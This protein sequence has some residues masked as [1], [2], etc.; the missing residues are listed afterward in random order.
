[1]DRRSQSIESR[2]FMILPFGN[3]WLAPD[4]N[5]RLTYGPLNFAAATYPSLPWAWRLPAP[6]LLVCSL[7]VAAAFLFNGGRAIVISCLVGIGQVGI[8]SSAQAPAVFSLLGWLS[9]CLTLQTV[10][11]L[12]RLVRKAVRSKLRCLLGLNKETPTMQQSRMLQGSLPSGFDSQL[13]PTFLPPFMVLTHSL[14]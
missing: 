10:C 5:N 6:I 4:L 11:R 7:V 13:L 3:V 12:D 2:R 9:F 8:V 14:P 1:M